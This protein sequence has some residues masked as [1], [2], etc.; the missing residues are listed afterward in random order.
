MHWAS[1][2][3]D[4]PELEQAIESVTA[5]IQKEMAGEAIDLAVAFLTSHHAARYS[6]FPGL[7]GR[8]IPRRKLI[9][10]SAGGVIGG[11]HEVE[12]R[13]GFA[14]TVAR[15]PDVEVTPF[16]IEAESLPDL[17]A[18]PR[19]WHDSIA[20]P[21][22]PLPHFV[23]L[24]DP[25][26]FPADDFLAG[27]DYAYPKSVKV[28]GLASAAQR[29]GENALYGNGETRRSGAI[30]V[31]LSGDIAIDTVVA[32]G[33]R[34]IGQ[35]MQITKAERNYLLKLDDRSPIEALRELILSLPDE[36]QELARNSLFVGVL[37]SELV[38]EPEAGDYLIRNILGMDPQREALAIGELVREG[39]RIQFHLR[40]AQTAAEDLVLL[41]SR[42]A[43]RSS[44]QQA[45][46]ALL[47]S[48]LGRGLLLY[49]YP[50]HDTGVF[51]EKIGDLPVGGFFCNGEIGPVGG[52]TRLHGYTSS[53]G[54]FRSAGEVKS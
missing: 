40:D 47:F 24:A 16:S 22:E 45:R 37:Q 19:A 36:D 48:C 18:S 41:L 1:S 34:P 4:A 7:L 27:L 28:G 44:S 32:Q 3:S 50:D 8:A 5:K 23:L 10:C 54:I 46:G 21:P 13:P 12:Q 31:A 51:K 29:P 14:L 35:P 20:V 33:C 2:V 9:G 17:D 53:F 38:S 30:G 49:G 43:E 11:G 52:S 42:F 15:L 6:D 26:S 39:Q 25:F